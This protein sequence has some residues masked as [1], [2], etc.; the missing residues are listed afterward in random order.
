MSRGRCS[1][2]RMCNMMA[3]YVEAQIKQRT[4]YVSKAMVRPLKTSFDDRI[5]ALAHVR[6]RNLKQKDMHSD[7]EALTSRVG[8][9][10]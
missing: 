1:K 9:I 10:G 4:A 7:V 8:I 2:T 3:G 6:Q 5:V